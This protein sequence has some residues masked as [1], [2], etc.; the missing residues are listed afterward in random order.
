MTTEGR[1]R[2]QLNLGVAGHLHSK[3]QSFITNF[4]IFHILI[5]SSVI[6][7]LMRLTSLNLPEWL[8]MSVS[9]LTTMAWKNMQQREPKFSCRGNLAPKC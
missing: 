3:G 1:V 9:W 6:F 7:L 5:G 4:S 8:L 2:L